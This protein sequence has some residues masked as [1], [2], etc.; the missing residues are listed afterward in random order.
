[1]LV[2]LEMSLVHSLSNNKLMVFLSFE[3]S[4]RGDLSACTFYGVTIKC[5]RS[6]LTF[7]TIQ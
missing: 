6:V 2:R 7:S 5:Y 4:L 3:S 1:M